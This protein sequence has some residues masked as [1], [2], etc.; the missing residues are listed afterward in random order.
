MDQHQDSARNRETGDIPLWRHCSSHLTR[1]AKAA[2]FIARIGTLGW[3]SRRDRSWIAPDAPGAVAD[4]ASA[5]QPRMRAAKI[6]D[7]NSSTKRPVGVTKT[8]LESL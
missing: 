3:R 2:E 7:A 5:P 6:V 1:G 8:S 4:R